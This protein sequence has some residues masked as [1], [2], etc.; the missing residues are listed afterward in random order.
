MKVKI[1]PETEADEALIGDIIAAVQQATAGR[2]VTYSLTRETRPVFG[3]SN[4][5]VEIPEV[6]FRIGEKTPEPTPEPPPESTSWRDRPPL[7]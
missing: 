2:Q 3:L 7:L 5:L 4:F 1:V 6:E